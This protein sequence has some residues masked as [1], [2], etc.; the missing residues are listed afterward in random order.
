MGTTPLAAGTNVSETIGGKEYGRS[1]L[2]DTAG[3]DAMGLVANA[4]AANTLLGRLKA[5]VDAV[6]SLIGLTAPANSFFAI[7]PGATA[8]ATVPAAIYVSGAGNLVV[9]GADGNDA[10]FVV[11]AG[12]I[13]PIRP[14]YVLGATTATGIVGLI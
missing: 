12:A 5:V 11:P 6:L 14:R 1:L 9:R 10:T 3:T 7:T 8:L 13:V 4:P 2:A